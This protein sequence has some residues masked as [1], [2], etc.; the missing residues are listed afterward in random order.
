MENQY[1]VGDIVCSKIAP[2]VPLII[3]SHLSRIY[4]CQIKENPTHTELAY[5][6]R[7]LMP[8]VATASPE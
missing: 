5:F 7:E 8:F 3:M 6:E 1:Q 2:T 4:Y